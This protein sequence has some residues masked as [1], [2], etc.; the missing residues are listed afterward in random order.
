MSQIRK[1][2]FCDEPG[3]RLPNRSSRGNEALTNGKAMDVPHDLS[4]VTSAA[5]A[6]VRI[7]VIFLLFSFARSHLVAQP[8]FSPGSAP[9]AAMM[10]EKHTGSSD[11][12][13]S[14]VVRGHNYQFLIEPT[15]T[16]L[17][18]C[19]PQPAAVSSTGSRYDFA[20]PRNVFTRVMRMQFRGASPDACIS[21]FG[22]LAG[23]INYLVGSDPGKWRR[24]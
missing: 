24:N 15:E 16:R 4:L 7:A 8:S 14:F 21:G 10:F 12:A 6:F 20:A 5:T 9:G 13:S 18:L 3:W 19:K 2:R 23:K 17:I 11:S 1:D 22:E